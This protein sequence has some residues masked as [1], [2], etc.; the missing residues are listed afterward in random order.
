[1]AVKTSFTDK[2]ELFRVP[3][4]QHAATY[5]V[6]SHES[7]VKH[8]IN[9]LSRA[10]FVI[11]QEVYKKNINGEVAYGIYNLDHSKDPDLSMMFAWSNTYDKSRRFR[12]AIGAEVTASGNHIMTGDVASYAR[13]HTGNADQQALDHIIS[14]I[15]MGVDHYTQIIA[16]KEQLLNTTLTTRQRSEILGVLVFEKEVLNL[17]QLA[18]VQKELKRPSFNYNYDQDSAFL[19]YNHIGHALK[20]SHPSVWMDNHQD[21]HRFFINE[22]GQVTDALAE[23]QAMIEESIKDLIRGPLEIL[24]AREEKTIIQFEEPEIIVAAPPV[25]ERRRVVFV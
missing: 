10:G 15:Q 5:T 2:N 4:P 19:L 6:I 8:A 11:R 16:D 1:M 7:I 3:L 24:E 14:Q 21:V 23:N 12:C 9:E 20:D 18:L 22:F 13:K 17:T 25:P